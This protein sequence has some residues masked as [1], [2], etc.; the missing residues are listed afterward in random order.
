MSATRSS[1]TLLLRQEEMSTRPD[2]A[3]APG[4]QPTETARCKE[5]S[6]EGRI[7][8]PARKSIQNQTRILRVLLLPLRLRQTETHSNPTRCRATRLLINR[9]RPRQRRL[10]LA[11][12]PLRRA[13]RPPAQLP[14][15][16]RNKTTIFIRSKHVPRSRLIQARVT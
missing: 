12:I 10:T 5:K 1:N 9:P 7:P 15:L 2:Q 6:L 13:P 14:R 11:L 8:V 16:R 4:L 3:I